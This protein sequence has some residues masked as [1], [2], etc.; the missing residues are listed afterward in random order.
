MP[1]KEYDVAIIGAGPAG[2]AAA[3]TIGPSGLRVL[4]IEKSACPEKVCGGLLCEEAVNL[5][6]SLGLEPPRTPSK[7]FSYFSIRI[8]ISEFRLEESY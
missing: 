2:F 5:L 3:R 7:R 6:S 4:L 8:T 1:A